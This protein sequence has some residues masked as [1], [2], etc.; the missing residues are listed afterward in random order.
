MSTVQSLID[1]VDELIRGSMSGRCDALARAAADRV[2][3]AC[4]ASHYA[5]ALEVDPEGASILVCYWGALAGMMPEADAAVVSRA[6][7]NRADLP[8]GAMSEPA[9]G[10]CVSPNA[11]LEM[12]AG[13]VSSSMY[14]HRGRMRWFHDIVDDDSE[15][16]EQA[17]EVAVGYRALGTAS[18]PDKDYLFRTVS[19]GNFVEIHASVDGASPGLTKRPASV[20]ICKTVSETWVEYEASDG[21]L[22]RFCPPRKSGGTPGG[23]SGPS[24]VRRMVVDALEASSVGNL[25]EHIEFRSHSTRAVSFAVDHASS[26]AKGKKPADMVAVVMPCVAVPR[27]VSECN[28]ALFQACLCHVVALTKTRRT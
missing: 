4:M 16:S 6:V 20:R 19:A 5:R 21:L 22:Y 11:G 15:W 17:E 18:A 8:A 13:S 3:P 28:A 2:L 26:M 1:K 24:F 12:Y 27:C 25:V 7:S 14:M 23:D 9:G 10:R